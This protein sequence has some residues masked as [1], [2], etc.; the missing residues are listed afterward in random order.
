MHAYKKLFAWIALAIGIG[1]AAALYSLW[2]SNLERQDAEETK[3]E[4][5]TATS[6]DDCYGLAMRFT[7]RRMAMQDLVTGEESSADRHTEYIKNQVAAFGDGVLYYHDCIA[8]LSSRG[9]P[10]DKAWPLPD[11]RPPPPP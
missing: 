2:V 8:L 4:Q 9:I 1:V 6:V 11:K 7:T 3:A 5:L 10:I